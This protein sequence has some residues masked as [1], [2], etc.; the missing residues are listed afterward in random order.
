MGKLNGA[1]GYVDLNTFDGDR[2]DWINY[3]NK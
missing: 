1:E 3:L 2:N